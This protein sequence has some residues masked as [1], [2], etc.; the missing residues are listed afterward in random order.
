ML[1]PTETTP[2]RGTRPSLC[3]R[4]TWYYVVP[5]SLILL[6]FLLCT[7]FS[8][9]PQAFVPQSFLHNDS[10]LLLYMLAAAKIVADICWLSLGQVLEFAGSLA[11]GRQRDPSQRRAIRKSEA[12][13]ALVKA[14]LKLLP[15]LGTFNLALHRLGLQFIP[16][17]IVF[18]VAIA[19]FTIILVIWA[20]AVQKGKVHRDDASQARHFGQF[21]DLPV[22]YAFDDS[23][24]KP[25]SSS[26]EPGHGGLGS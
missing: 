16:P 25:A 2:L 19:G 12:P 13:N 17:A 6:L 20:R 4:S 26:A 14:F 22:F 1:P 24:Y 10:D 23:F 3:P 11:I 21:V 7:L 9:A 8:I 18:L 15:F 5:Y